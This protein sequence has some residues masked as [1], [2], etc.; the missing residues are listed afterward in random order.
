MS[1]TGI[2]TKAVTLKALQQATGGNVGQ[3]HIHDITP[4]PNTDEIVFVATPHDYGRLD[5]IHDYLIHANHRTGFARRTCGQNIGDG[6][7]GA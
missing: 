7:L 1:G 3:F 6:Q 2:V 4:L 5:V